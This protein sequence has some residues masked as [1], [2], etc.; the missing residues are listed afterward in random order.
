MK[1]TLP[2]LSGVAL[3]ISAASLLSACATAE[4]KPTA[5]IDLVQCSGVNKCNGHNDCKTASNNCA[6]HAS[7]KGQGFV[8]MPA[9]ACA[10]VGG[11]VSSNSAA[12]TISKTDLIHCSGVNKCSGHNDCKTATNACAGHASCKGQGFV[13]TTTKSCA[14][15]GG[16]ES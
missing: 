10:D 9:K 16:T 1:K 13:A 14:D 6:G 8:L 3:A 12:K 11:S 7:C 5:S 4:T 2:K 15:I